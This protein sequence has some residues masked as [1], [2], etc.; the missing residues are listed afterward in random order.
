MYQSLLKIIIKIHNLIFTQIP[1]YCAQC[2]AQCES[3]DCLLAPKAIGL[4]KLFI[5]SSGY[6][7]NVLFFEAQSTSIIYNTEP[8]HNSS[9]GFM[10]LSMVFLPKI[11][12][13]VTCHINGSFPLFGGVSHFHKID[14]M[15]CFGC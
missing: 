12:V 15:A 1:Q 13:I 11:F 9:I 7:V 4:F 5:C 6:H 2:N 3:I 14:R 8:Q 10:R